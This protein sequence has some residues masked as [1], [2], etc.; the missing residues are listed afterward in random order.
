MNNL[1]YQRLSMDTISTNTLQGIIFIGP[2]CE[3]AKRERG[4]KGRIAV[5]VINAVIVSANPFQNSI[6]AHPPPDSQKGRAR[7]HGGAKS[8]IQTHAVQPAV[9]AAL[10][11]LGERGGGPHGSLGDPDE[12]L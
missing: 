6:L 9:S 12:E 1:F 11:A 7:A 3:N 8:H 5:I 2:V 10:L 4:G